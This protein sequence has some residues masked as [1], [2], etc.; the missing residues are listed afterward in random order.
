MSM[1]TKFLYDPAADGSVAVD[2]AAPGADKSVATITWVDP[3]DGKTYQ[4]TPEQAVA[5][6]NTYAGKA[7]EFDAT[8]QARAELE[9]W[10][11]ENEGNVSLA[12]QIAS[13]KAALEKDPYDWEATATLMRAYGVDEVTIESEIAKGRAAQTTTNAGTSGQGTGQGTAGTD[14][15]V[16]KFLREQSDIIRGLKEEVAQLRGSSEGRDRADWG[17]VGFDVLTKDKVWA[18]V[19]QDSEQGATIRKDVEA[20]IEAARKAG[21][22]LNEATIREATAQIRRFVDVGIKHAPKPLA[23]DPSVLGGAVPG[24]A[25]MSQFQGKDLS[26]KPSAEQYRDPK[27]GVI[28]F[29]KFLAHLDAHRVHEESQ[30]ADIQ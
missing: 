16:L 12:S 21:K 3:T 29:D 20:A 5:R 2:N 23:V 27:S 13:A 22:P 8:A 11:K 6:L 24:V 9:K 26:K 18:K 25:L 7:K 10:K 14:P 30:R 15:A 28:D 19:L 1:M 17:K 4:L